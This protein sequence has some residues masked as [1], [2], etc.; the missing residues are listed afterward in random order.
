MKIDDLETNLARTPIEARK[1]KTECQAFKKVIDDAVNALNKPKEVDDKLKS[2]SSDLGALSTG[3]TVAKVVRPIRL[4]AGR[5]QTSVKSIRKSVDKWEAK[6]KALEEKAKPIR[7]ELQA[8]SKRID[9]FIK[10]LDKLISQSSSAL[11]KIRKVHGCVNSLQDPL[12]KLG[13]AQ[14]NDFA[15]VSNQPVVVL[16]TNMTRVNDAIKK[17]RAQIRQIVA[18]LNKLKQILKEIA[19]LRKVIDPIMGPLKKLLRALNQKINLKMFSF[20]IRQILDGLKL[21][22]P[23]SYLE[24]AFWS[25]ANRILDPI[26]KALKLDV[27]LP[28][29]PGLNL[30]G[31]INFDPFEKMPDFSGMLD[32]LTGLFGNLN[33]LMKLFK[34]TCPPR[35]SAPT[36]SEALTS[37]LKG[38]RPKLVA[39]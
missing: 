16:N 8:L 29:I 1:L 25:T 36:T 12:R 38:A 13:L 2:L 26:L 35:Q 23:F 22:W 30:L 24:K 17:S 32:D 3:L 15:R 19:S 11:E 4:V 31:K 7:Q 21:P 18:Q 5:L 10:E 37:A 28:G 34:V 6:A 14:L 27:K 20:S 9:Q 39:A 33:E